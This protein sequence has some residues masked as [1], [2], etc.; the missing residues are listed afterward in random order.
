MDV[1]KSIN[2]YEVFQVE[3]EKSDIT[4]CGITG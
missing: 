3:K 1:N 2:E 4:F